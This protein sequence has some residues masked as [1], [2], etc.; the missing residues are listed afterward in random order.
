MK[1]C[2]TCGAEFTDDTPVC[3][4]CGS[5]LEYMTSENAVNT[6]E[7]AVN[8][9]ENAAVTN[10][11]GSITNETEQPAKPKKSKAGLVIVIIILLAALGVGGFYLYKYLTKSPFEILAEKLSQLEEANSCT[12]NID[13]KFTTDG[14]DVPLSGEVLIEKNDKTLNAQMNISAEIPMFSGLEVSGAWSADMEKKTAKFALSALEQIQ[15]YS[16]DLSENDGTFDKLENAKTLD[17]AVDAIIDIIFENADDEELEKLNKEELK[18]CIKES[19]AYLN[20]KEALK[21]IWHYEK[22]DDVYSFDADLIAV[23]NVFVENMKPAFKDAKDYEEFVADFNEDNDGCELS[24]KMS[25]IVKNGNLT[26]LSVSA[27]DEKDSQIN[28]LFT[29][30]DNIPTDVSLSLSDKESKTDMSLKFTFSEYNKTKVEFSDEMLEAFENAEELKPD[31][32][33]NFGS[34]SD[35]NGDD[36]NGDNDT[37]DNTGTG[38]QTS[39]YELIARTACEKHLNDYGKFASEAYVAIYGYEE[40]WIIYKIE[41]ERPVLVDDEQ[42]K[43][44]IIDKLF[45]E[46]FDTNDM[47]TK[48][49]GYAN[50]NTA[51]WCVIEN[52]KTCTTAFNDIADTYDA[53]SA[54]GITLNDGTVFVWKSG[55]KKRIFKLSEG[56]GIII[57]ANSLEDETTAD[58]EKVDTSDI[59]GASSKVKVYAVK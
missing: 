32:I 55:S 17:E 37:T 39:D 23:A 54:N 27:K 4:I 3:P 48:S 31:D 33:L 14:T 30:K 22:K 28:F 18:A 56:G 11:E 26:S 34:N 49:E 29:V 47:W 51:Y 2:K 44:D 36:D 12:T 25:F 53:L 1:K 10:F 52:D 24:L 45:G 42:K 13:G 57:I 15:A 20:S 6:D 58:L 5:E 8:T 43:Q 19:L 50:G 40:D 59:E 41:S 21:E 9:D 46:S 16:I 7:N 38:E 35:D